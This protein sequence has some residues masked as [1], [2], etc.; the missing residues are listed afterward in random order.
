MQSTVKAIAARFGINMVSI[1][2]AGATGFSGASVWKI[3]DDQGG[4]YSI[5]HFSSLSADQLAWIHRVQ[6]H[7]IVCDC[8]FVA[9]PLR[10]GD[11]MSLVQTNDGLWEVCTWML[12]EANSAA[13]IS[14]P[15]L[16][17]AMKSLAK[18]HQSAAQ[19][20]FDFRPSPGVKTR[21]DQ[22]AKFNMIIAAIQIKSN[23]Y[24]MLGDL[25]L[26]LKQ[27]SPTRLN[28]FSSA[29]RQF[30]NYTF[31][32]QPVIRDLRA[33]HLLFTDDNLTGLIDFDAMQMES[34]ALDLTRSLGDLI[35]DDTDRWQSAL[36]A[37]NSVRPIQAA[38]L[39][40][41]KILD[42]I[43]V[44]LSAMNWIK[45]IVIE[46]RD[47][48]NEIAVEVRLREINQRLCIVLQAP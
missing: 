26:Q 18:F 34:I 21:L 27:V 23:Q 31:P 7:T 11:G 24:P 12:G 9:R 29:L 4:Y 32:L 36:E 25:L 2:P 47:F 42:P 28:D 44:I 14:E 40:L 6:L 37:Y 46:G 39:E 15:R 3:T 5:K 35:P 33:E 38:E 41:I 19:V 43:N 17:H 10:T 22:L 16:S 45:W 48:E 20:N 1:A 30:E 13:P 8:D